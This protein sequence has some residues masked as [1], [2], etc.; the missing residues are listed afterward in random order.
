MD[1]DSSRVEQ[2]SISHLTEYVFPTINLLKNYLKRQLEAVL[3]DKLE[4]VPAILRALRYSNLDN[5]RRD[6]LQLLLCVEEIRIS[7]LPVLG[8]EE[9]KEADDKLG[10]S[11]KSLARSVHA[12]PDN[13]FEL[14]S[15]NSTKGLEIKINSL[16]G[17]LRDKLF[18]EEVM[19]SIIGM[20]QSKKLVVPSELHKS[21]IT[22][23]KSAVESFSFNIRKHTIRRLLGGDQGSSD[24]EKN[25]FLVARINEALHPALIE[26]L[27]QLQQMLSL[28]TNY[29]DFRRL[30]ACNYKTVEAVIEDH[31]CGHDTLV[32]SGVSHEQATKILKRASIIAIRNER[33]A[34]EALRSKGPKDRG[35]EHE[36][37]IT[38]QQLVYQQS[39][40][41]I[42]LSTMF[43][44]GSMME[45]DGI[46][47]TSPAA[48]FVHLLDSL[49]KVSFGTAGG[50]ATT[51]QD[52]LF[53][54]RPDLKQLDL[55]YF[56]T[57]I[58]IRYIDLVNEILEAIAWEQSEKLQKPL[59]P[60]NMESKD[61]AEPKFSEP[62]HTHLEVYEK[63]V[64]PMVSPMTV[65]PYNHA[66]QSVRLLL[67]ACGVPLIQIL[68]TFS[69]PDR[70]QFT[71]N[72]PNVMEMRIISINRAWAAEVLG[73]QYEDYVA[74]TTE[75]FYPHNEGPR[76]DYL[77]LI[78]CRKT[79]EYW[80]YDSEHDILSSSSGLTLVQKETMP[81]SG[82]SFE[83]L[84]SI[85]KSRHFCDTLQIK[86]D[87][88]KN[89]SEARIE[90]KDGDSTTPGIDTCQRLQAFVRLWRKLPWTLHEL[91]I[92]LSMFAGRASIDAEVIG[93]I[94]CVQQIAEL[95]ELPLVEIQ[96]LWGDIDKYDY[97]SL[98]VYS[99]YNRRFLQS[100]HPDE[101]F[102]PK[103]AVDGTYQY[104]NT[105]SNIVDYLP[106][107]LE[108]VQ[109]TMEE[110]LEI[111]DLVPTVLTMSSLTQLYR[112]STLC[113]ILDVPVDRY[114]L[115]MSVYSSKSQ[116]DP[117]QDPS[118]TLALIK[119][120]KASRFSLDELLFICTGNAIKSDDAYNPTQKNIEKIVNA[121]I[122]GFSA[123]D[124]Y[125]GKAPLSSPWQIV[126]EHLHSHFPDVE[127]NV[128]EYFLSASVTTGTRNVTS[129][130]SLEIL[131][132]METEP[133]TD[134][135]FLALNIKIPEILK[136]IILTNPHIIY[137]V[138]ML[139]RRLMHTAAI[140][141]RCGLKKAE[142]EMLQNLKIAFIGFARPDLQE[143][144]ELER[145]CQLR[146][147]FPNKKERQ[148]LCDFYTSLYDSPPGTVEHLIS[149]LVSVSGWS[150]E[151]CA[152]Y[153]KAKYA[154][155]DT[156][157][158][159]EE[160]DRLANC[161][162]NLSALLEM[163]N[164]I[165]L[166]GKLRLSGISLEQ[167]FALAEP[168]LPKNT[169]EL[170]KIHAH[171]FPR[172][173]FPYYP[174]PPKRSPPK[175]PP[176]K[177]PPTESPSP[178]PPEPS[179]TM[180][181]N[182][183][184]EF[185]K[186]LR[187]AIRNLR[188]MPGSGAAFD[189]A[190]DGIRTAQRD[191]MVQYLLAHSYAREN[192]IRDAEE[193]FEHL[194]IDVK[195]GPVLQTSRLKQ[196]I[197]TVQL[198]VQRCLLGVERRHGITGPKLR[199]NKSVEWDTMFRYRLWEAER[200]VLLHPETWVDP[201]L[202][203]DKTEQFLEFETA[204]TQTKLDPES[205]ATLTKTYLYEIEKL[206]N[207]EIVNYLWDRTGSGDGR[208]RYADI[209]FFGRTRTWP[210]SFYYRKLQIRPSEHYN[211]Q[212]MYFWTP[213][214]K[215]DIDVPVYE[216]DADGRRLDKPG[217][218]LIPAVI[219]GRLTLFLP[220]ITLVQ[221]S[222]NEFT[223]SG[224][225]TGQDLLRVEMKSLAPQRWWEVR[226]GRTERRNGKWL[227]KSVPQEAI[228]CKPITKHTKIISPGG[229]PGYANVEK[230]PAIDEFNFS[231][232]DTYRS[233]SNPNL[234]IEVEYRYREGMG[235]NNEIL[236][237]F[238][239]GAFECHGHQ[240]IRRQRELYETR[241][242]PSDITSF[243]KTIFK[244]HGNFSGEGALGPFGA[245]HVDGKGSPEIFP[246]N[247]T[248]SFDESHKSFK[249]PPRSSSPKACSKA[250]VFDQETTQQ[251]CLQYVGI[252]KAFSKE[253]FEV[254]FQLYDFTNL[255]TA[256]LIDCVNNGGEVDTVHQFLHKIGSESIESRDTFGL[257]HYIDDFFHERVRPFSIYNW[258]LGVH[259]PMLLAERLMATQQYALALETLRTIFD[260]TISDDPYQCWLFPPFVDTI[261]K[262]DTRQNEPLVE[263]T[264]MEQ[265][266]N[267]NVHVSARNSPEVY[268]KRIM[269]K[270]I[271]V[272]IGMGDLFFRQAT[273]ES[274]PLAIERYIQAS[275]LFGARPVI[276]PKLVETKA[277]TYENLTKPDQNFSNG[278]YNATLDTA[279]SGI[280]V[281]N[282][283]KLKT[284]GIAP[285]K[286]SYFSVPPNPY[287][288]DLGKKIDQRLYNIR[289]GLD[290]NGIPISLPLFEPPLDP[291]MV[292]AA[293]ALRSIGSS[294]SPFTSQDGPI[295]KYRFRYLIHQAYELVN[296]LRLA[297]QQLIQFKEKRDAEAIWLLRTKHQRTVLGLTM[298]IK[299]SQRLD[300]EKGIE[301]LQET[302]KQLEMRLNYYLQLT[303]DTPTFPTAEGDHWADVVQNIASPT[304]DDLRM[305][306]FE[307]GEMNLSEKASDMNIAAGLLDVAAAAA[308]AIP[309][310]SVKTQP[311]G[312]GSDVSLG[313]YVLG[314]LIQSQAAAVKVGAQV[315][316]DQAVKAARAGAITKQLQ[317]RRLEINVTGREIV[318]VDKEIKQLRVRL[319]VCDADMKA[320]EQEIENAVAEEEWLR[321][322][323]TS[324]QLYALLENSMN[325]IFQQTYTMAADMA[326]LARRA[327]N[328]EHA[329]RF[330]NDSKLPK[331]VNHWDHSHDG[332]LSAE[333]MYLDLKQLEKLHME[334]RTH[335]FEIRKSI[336]L[337]QLNPIELLKLRETGEAILDVPE[338]LFDMDYPGHFCRRISSVSVS[339]PC[340]LGAYTSLSCTLRLT[341]HGYRISP[342][343]KTPEKDAFRQD[344]V[345][346]TSIAVSN[347][348]QDS[349]IFNMDFRG[350][351]EYGPFE[352][353][354]AISTWK[355][356]L[357]RY[358][359]H[360]TIIPYLTWYFI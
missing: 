166:V 139:V 91:D 247:W 156:S 3:S 269:L 320:H 152:N 226:M 18:S 172:G 78:D 116:F 43:P 334:S 231:L 46:S 147:V 33:I 321:N 254:K 181:W 331:I 136:P 289:N 190:Y 2:D 61:A 109:L 87:Q 48:F 239:Y 73:L 196:A 230:W 282:G 168:R 88:P 163:S 338:A 208:M 342:D 126:V 189:K 140:V 58:Q 81:R 110:Y 227:P 39:P 332:H 194:L 105:D 274:I 340:I 120:H 262:L 225:K 145:Y 276:I 23:F 169:L 302:R 42:N 41:G 85:I 24:A 266:E 89:L 94:A 252:P 107:I 93:K 19:S 20:L 267:N 106:T 11:I 158:T 245:K 111:K 210:V 268:M 143:I 9:R 37:S 347:G 90:Q 119:D 295:P 67:K 257:H 285:S 117:F 236:N 99:L 263:R 286:Y 108:G 255:L 346:I 137:V 273:L 55:S 173:H 281:L 333:S 40:R 80:G 337:R 353:A 324:E 26:Y 60:F 123:T 164:S 132:A 124:T 65:F 102:F 69:A 50:K 76:D 47:V 202:R 199:A 232:L 155:D 275:H 178:E 317:E 83:E 138:V 10:L 29:D 261:K 238:S 7:M 330:H 291:A 297:S 188:I 322:K 4:L 229:K 307:L 179:H 351:D 237:S 162:R 222:N 206:A 6:K 82:L 310:F 191:A 242:L 51:L 148:P 284:L 104:F 323:Y 159:K 25:V 296:E 21:A 59:P 114:K 84:L 343:L 66:I 68:E 244:K 213:W 100:A 193:L 216:T 22:A 180:G 62:Q 308:F 207:L 224:T 359:S 27:V 15:S 287:I 304:T 183:Y 214:E 157:N 115:L 251:G 325:V 161:F 70:I 38:N 201:T 128:L 360:S 121:M 305:S 56:N 223:S 270:Y 131:L 220:E 356:E 315:Y 341:K 311:M 248:I 212:D 327:L 209:H 198:F 113:K 45:D 272:L 234:H 265:Y 300:T 170:P 277:R 154:L 77:K 149:L 185:E 357:P 301:V 16:W 218:Y 96:P 186:A 151:M 283:H 316:T 182:D 358:S 350:T 112:I 30:I 259:I 122:Q 345:P 279:P 72:T 250:L 228:Q 306:P 313:G 205:I 171:L 153:I 355:I 13:L 49:K 174:P 294:A 103:K 52:K 144:R 203:D 17:E 165:S 204:M 312:M 336:S 278:K 235:T 133:I 28:T 293:Q 98:K 71:T 326:S 54:R 253:R 344:I 258:E 319:D 14:L 339:I 12:A 335:D 31:W 292:L 53:E 127:K 97:T 160:A 211:E 288:I 260:P 86:P 36:T 329:T 175:S 299:K 200:K 75:G 8:L 34:I 167:L 64:Q 1:P 5:G 135:P 233:E 280:A 192:K 249:T 118:T 328:F 32:Q 95:T 303:G 79:W 197:S 246:H 129:S 240:L 352:G 130:S 354:G 271:E 243:Q 35:M 318:K 125:D 74:I 314:Q 309:T 101:I 256:R 141:K 134:K 264:I 241:E 44:M 177:S 298:R 195:M 187:K 142:I 217:S 184:F 215:L 221:S 219:Q 348:V 349:G 146:E 176:T 92:F 63:Y 290:I 57:S 150:S